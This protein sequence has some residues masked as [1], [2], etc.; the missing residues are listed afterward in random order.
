MLNPV[1]VSI[2]S[3]VFTNRT[4]RS[5][6]IAIWVGM[7]GLGMA[8]GPELG[9]L[10]V[11]TVGW[12]G[13]FWVNVP[14]G[15]C[16]IV[17]TTLFVPESRAAEPRRP[18][19]VAQ[20]L[21]IV[22]LASLVYAI[23]EGAYTDWHA[24]IIRGLFAVAAGAMA[25]LAV[26]ELRRKDPL[27]RPAPLP[28]PVIHRGRADRHLRVR[29][30]GRLPLPHH[31]LPAGRARFLGHPR[32]A[33]TCCR[34]PR[35]WRVCP[36]LAA[37]LTAKTGSARLPLLLGGLALMLSTNLMS[38]LVGSS[39]DVRLLL[40]FGLFG[41]GMGMVNS[42]ISVAAVAGMPPGQAGLA[43]GIASASRQLGQALGVAVTGALLTA[44]ARGGG[45][46]A[47]FTLASYPAW[48][49]LFWCAFVVVIAGLMTTRQRARHE[50]A[51]TAVRRGRG[52]R[53]GSFAA[54]RPAEDLSQPSSGPRRW[55]GPPARDRSR[56]ARSRP[57]R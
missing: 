43:S 54:A 26:W 16:A 8:L 51:R 17:L 38:R 5:R 41:L 47:K 25:A 10:L 52:R 36:S 42:Q 39:S 15:L 46:H 3:G 4:Q 11:G 33:C 31:H 29:G 20:V 1:A 34:P 6:A 7:F 35:P 48:H 45:M 49:V 56:R 9:G 50:M 19:P 23:I 2:I 44:K 13:I 55:P 14:V 22:V 28:Q 32:R 57:G 37:W 40:T 53:A 12:R 30:P 18:D 21:V 27:D 24:A